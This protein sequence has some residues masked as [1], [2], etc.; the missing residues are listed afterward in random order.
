MDYRLEQIVN[1]PAG[2]HPLLD[3]LMRHIATGAQ[4][5]FIAIIVVW[6]VSGWLR[7]KQQD[8]RG[9][10]SAGIAAA[11]SLLINQITI[12]LWPRDRP[13]VTHPQTVHLLLAHKP[14]PSFPSD[15]AAPAFAI[16]AVLF[17]LHRRIGILTITSA[18]VM[19][20]ARVYSGDHYPGDVVAG[21]IV[22]IVVAVAVFTC[23]GGLSA[24]VNSLFD[25]AITLLH[26]P[27]RRGD[28][29]PG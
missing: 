13:F 19:C 28:S 22:G 26:I 6:F 3:S 20:Y 11:G 1:G 10:I 23:L 29:Q 16:A 17:I 7:G 2:S 15:H 21:A 9:A 25:Q 8:R 24:R 14:D 5:F 27:D 4:P 12:R 18:A